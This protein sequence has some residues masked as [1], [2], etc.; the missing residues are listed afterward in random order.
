[1]DMAFAD[2]FELTT[3]I[4]HVLEFGF[5][6]AR[7]THPRLIDLD[8]SFHDVRRSLS[9]N[10]DKP[11]QRDCPKCN[12]QLVLDT[13]ARLEERDPDGLANPSCFGASRGLLHASSGSLFPADAASTLGLNK[14]PL[15]T[16]NEN[17][18]EPHASRHGPNIAKHGPIPQ[19]QL[20]GERPDPLAS[21]TTASADTSLFELPN[22][23]SA[24]DS[25]TEP[26]CNSRSLYTGEN[27]TTRGGC[28]WC[29]HTRC[30]MATEPVHETTS[31]EA[32]TLLMPH[33]TWQMLMSLGEASVWE[34]QE[35]VW[36]S[37]GDASVWE[38]QVMIWDSL[39]GAR[40]W[41][42]KGMGWDHAAA[43]VS[44]LLMLTDVLGGFFE[45][46]SRRPCP[47][48]T[49]CQGQAMMLPPV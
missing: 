31:R 5:D 17:S 11:W 46:H 18:G 23:G 44:I 40:V 32:D 24:V 20:H 28:D 15:H 42:E 34:G 4:M 35:M 41:E 26:S 10:D 7:E 30:E 3:R 38:R 48:S 29:Q 8:F 21:S 36:D 49:L 39:G 22:Q 1:M 25:E 37:L 47:E 27:C 13:I 45:W 19:R 43:A 33:R 9:R 2:L 6:L 16:P 12:H 14:E